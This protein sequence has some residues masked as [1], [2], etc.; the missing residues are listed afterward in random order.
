MTLS[1]EDR[2]TSNVRMV[3]VVQFRE[4]VDKLEIN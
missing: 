3:D 4:L 2:N 1:C